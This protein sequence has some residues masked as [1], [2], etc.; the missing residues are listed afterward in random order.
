[1][2]KK[3]KNKITELELPDLTIRPYKI[4]ELMSNGMEAV[5]KDIA[6]D[7]KDEKYN[8]CEMNS[9]KKAGDYISK[10]SKIFNI[11]VIDE[12]K[13][14]NEYYGHDMFRII[15]IKSNRAVEPD[16]TLYLELMR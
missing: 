14:K 3:S 12:L 2:K 5:L 1:M 4:S 9:R 7:T 15:K 11:R 16:N 10:L 6:V 13:D 8:I